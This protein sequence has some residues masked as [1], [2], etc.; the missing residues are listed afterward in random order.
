MVPLPCSC[1]FR[2][3]GRNV[4]LSLLSF[5]LL[6]AGFAPPGHAQSGLP[7]GT[8]AGSCDSWA[9]VSDGAFGLDDP[10]H[11]TPPYQSED[12]FEVA[13]FDGQLYVG[14]EADDL[15]GARLWRTRDG[16]TVPASQADW[17]QVVNDAFGDVSNNDHIDSLVSFGGNLYAST[18]QKDASHNGTEVWRSPSGDLGTWEQ[19]NDDGFGDQ[20][21]ENFKDMAVFTVGGTDWLC[22]GT[23]NNALGA[24]VWCTDGSLS[25]GG[26]RLTWVQKN[27]NGFGDARYV[28][29]WS[30]G[31]KDGYLYAGT[32]CWHNDECPGA[33]WRTDGAPDGV[34]D[35][36]RW[37]WTMVFD[38]D[39][40]GRVDIV[41][42]YDGYLY[43]GLDGGSGTEIW[44]SPSGDAGTWS[45]ANSDGFGD[46]NNGRAIVDAATVYN[47]ALYLATLNQATGAEVWR[48]SDGATWSQVNDDGFG[49]VHTFAAELIPFN[50]YLYAWATNYTT[51]QQVLRSKCPLCQSQ[52]IDGTG[53]Y[54]FDGVGATLDFTAESLDSVEVCV[55]PGAFPTGQTDDKPVKRHYEVNASPSNGTF[56]ADLTFSYTDEELSASDI[57]DEDTTYLARWTGSGWSACP[58]GSRSRN[59]ENNT[60]TCRGVS[61]FSTWA[62]G[63]SN[64]PPTAVT[65]LS[66]GATAEGGAI[67]LEW[68]TA[69]ELDTL[70]FHLYRS[71]A[72]A[73]ERLR[74][75][76]VLI[77][78]DGAGSPVGARYEFEDRTATPGVP[79]D[80]WLEEVDLYGRAGL[81]GPAAAT[82]AAAAPNAV[83][84]SHLVAR[85]AIPWLPLGLAIALPLT[86]LGVWFL[87]R[88]RRP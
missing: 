48:T 30:T 61:A 25:G 78:G 84:L 58:E 39:T 82:L 8:Y 4:V 13:V 32:E 46:A 64:Q 37:Q 12:A 54:S 19:V 55:Y 56:A 45:Q 47:G 15:Y 7:P 35:G 29:V 50:G 83:V 67:L 62:V 85:E 75:N 10:S 88:W 9:Q 3:K 74:L 63:G 42:V 87:D 70:G 17:E 72:P 77:P 76:E 31:V 11:Q 52:T 57:T 18:A 80:Y 51:G 65:L 1:T 27:L 71:E 6:A 23:L 79:Y 86:A 59:V 66:F 44:R 81:H 33:V 73:G 38:A 34:A 14:M 28:K 21:N 69:S 36:N 53:S 20:D 43:V 22:G 5:A 16:V 49:D 2:L 40:N 24:Q 41:G 68:E 26:P 60:A